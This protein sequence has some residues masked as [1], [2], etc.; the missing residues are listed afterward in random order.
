MDT[1]ARLLVRLRRAGVSWGDRPL[2]NP[3]FRPDAGSIAAYLVDAEIVERHPTLSRG[4][5]GYDVELATERAAELLDLET[6][7]LLPEDID[8]LEVAACL[9]ERYAALWEE[10]AREEIFRPE[11]QRYRVA[12]R[13][14]RLGDLGFDVGEVELVTSPEATRLRVETRVAEPGRHRHELV[15]LTGLEVQEKQARRLLDDLRS[16][17]AQLG[18][19]TGR[20]MSVTVAGHRWLAEVYLPVV[21]AV[22]TGLAGRLAPA[23]VFH[24][25][26]EHRWFLSEEAGR[27]VG[28]TAAA[29][30]YLA[31]VL[32]R[33]PSE[34]T[35]PSVLLGVR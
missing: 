28:T 14:Q 32:P 24:E 1:I 6:G 12:E 16:F 4:Q 5:R 9:P 10:I 7:G 2:S 29:E 19:S 17:R 13:L 27:D 20:P 8:P 22:P 11:E 31:T 30:S 26:L 35:T 33:T 18:Q 34:V 21:D 25:V 15:R 23:E 3:L